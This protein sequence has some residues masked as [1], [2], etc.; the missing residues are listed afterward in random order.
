MKISSRRNPWLVFGLFL[1]VLWS[2]AGAQ[3]ADV[4]AGAKRAA[5]C[6]ACHGENGVAVVPGTPHLAGQDRRY[7]EA[8]LA[9]YRNGQ[10]L[11]ATMVAMAKPLSDAD[12]AN[13]A[14]YFHLSR[15]V[16][17]T[18]S[19]RDVVAV[20]ANLAHAGAVHVGA[21]PQQGSQPADGA[22]SEP[23]QA[24]APRT[25]A[26]LYGRTC[27]ACHG[28]GAAGAP[29]LG[30]SNAW[31]PR[32]AQGRDTLYKHTLAGLNAMPPRGLC[33][34]CTDEELQ[35]VV[36]HMASQSGG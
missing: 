6:F 5:V 12:I 36:D 4:A 22:D 11:D 34:D 7:I 9:A 35:R 2:S 13:I 10:R 24:V 17:P 23:A 30:D 33:A 3:I 19:F 28:T 15:S 8:A 1:A 18:E 29:R 21:V 26:E 25:A 32:I 27:S 16:P 31:A 20:Q 14:A